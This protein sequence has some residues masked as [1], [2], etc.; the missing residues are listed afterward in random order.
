MVFQEALKNKVVLAA[1]IQQ[2]A[3][4]ACG[5]PKLDSPMV[6]RPLD[7]AD[8]PLRVLSSLHSGTKTLI[9]AYKAQH[10]SDRKLVYI[11]HRL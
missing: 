8:L 11:Y 4:A 2:T 10:S 6:V 9:I 3:R 7:T 5:C 1:V